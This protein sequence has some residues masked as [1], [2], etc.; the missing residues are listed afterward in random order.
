M[1]NHVNVRIFHKNA[2]L[3]VLVKIMKS[4][5][6]HY[7]LGAIHYDR[8]TESVE[9]TGVS[10]CDKNFIVNETAKIFRKGEK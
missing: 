9:L 5:S 8:D 1:N 3:E 10:D 2:N 6:E 4:V 7:G